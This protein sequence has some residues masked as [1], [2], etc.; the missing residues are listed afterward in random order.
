MASDV[1]FPHNNGAV[2]TVA[3]RIKAVMTSA[4]ESE[5]GAM[6]INTRKAV[7]IRTT[8]VE[9]GHDQPRTSMQTNSSVAHLV[10]IKT[11]QS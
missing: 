5:I 3:Q 1:E 4:A 6:Y 9:I 7:P 10:V 11:E 8:L 2:H